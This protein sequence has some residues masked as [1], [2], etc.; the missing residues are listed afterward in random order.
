MECP[1][2]DRDIIEIFFS[3]ETETLLKSIGEEKNRMKNLA[4]KHF[5]MQSY[6]TDHLITTDA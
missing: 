5:F 2:F 6:N 4:V 1:S 3:E